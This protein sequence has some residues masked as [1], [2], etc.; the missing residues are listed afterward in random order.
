MNERSFRPYDIKRIL[1]DDENTSKIIDFC[2]KVK[3]IIKNK[4]SKYYGFAKDNE[5]YQIYCLTPKLAF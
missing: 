3:R 5:F 2:Y 1:K 4:T